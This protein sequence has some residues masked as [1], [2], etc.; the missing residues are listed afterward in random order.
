ML[1][2]TVMV[3]DRTLLVQREPSRCYDS[4]LAGSAV[5]TERGTLRR[6]RKRYG[7][8]TGHGLECFRVSKGGFFSE[9]PRLR[10][11]LAHPAYQKRPYDS[12]CLLY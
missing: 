8:Q 4:L 1:R 3:L 6:R 7:G 5:I 9:I 10:V 2:V 11:Y 12:T